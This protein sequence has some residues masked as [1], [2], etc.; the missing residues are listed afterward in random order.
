MPIDILS[1]AN[2]YGQLT[3][4]VNKMAN[5]VNSGSFNPMTSANVAVTGIISFT[6]SITPPTITVTQN[7]YAPS[8]FATTSVIRNAASISGLS[9][10]GL[11]GGT[12]GRIILLENV[13][14][15]TITLTHEDP[16]S[17]ATNRFSIGTSVALDT[18]TTIFLRYD[19][20]S[21]RWV[22]VG[23]FEQTAK[24]LALAIAL[25]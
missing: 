12:S 3:T 13:G 1:F 25:G 18:N 16:L 20:T 17:T 7:N 6:A 14:V 19:G 24:S 22:G 11:A 8:G 9:I 15:F 23:S 5:T 10:T 2:T 4:T 21:N